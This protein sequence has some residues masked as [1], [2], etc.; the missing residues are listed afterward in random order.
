MP[1]IT[2]LKFNPDPVPLTAT[3]FEF[4]LVD[5]AGKKRHYKIKMK[6]NDKKALSS[7]VFALLKAREKN[8][9]DWPSLKKINVDWNLEAIQEEL[10]LKVAGQFLLI[11]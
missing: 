4:S 3:Q 10:A 6:D 7:L 2:N 5:H 1:R 8:W 11:Y 9:I